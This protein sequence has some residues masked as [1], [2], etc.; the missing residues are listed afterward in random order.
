MTTAQMET[1]VRCIQ[2][3]NINKCGHFTQKKTR[4]REKNNRKSSIEIVFA[5]SKN[6]ENELYGLNKQRKKW[7]K[8]VSLHTDT[9]THIYIVS[10]AMHECCL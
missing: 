5:L 3:N 1:R 6:R 2:Q 7:Q 9:D 4:R 8:S 10:W